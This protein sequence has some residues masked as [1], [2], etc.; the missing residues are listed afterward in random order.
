MGYGYDVKLQVDAQGLECP[1]PV[2][3]AKRAIRRIEI[4]EVMEVCTTDPL[5]P[6]DVRAWVRSAGHDLV[7]ADDET[8]PFRFFI[9]RNC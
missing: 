2:I 3:E 6:L 1:F 9:R 7:R 5:S 4:G 8:V